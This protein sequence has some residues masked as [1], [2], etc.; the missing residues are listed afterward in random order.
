MTLQRYEKDLKI[1]K[2]TARP[3]CILYKA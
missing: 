1:V 3:Q 2:K